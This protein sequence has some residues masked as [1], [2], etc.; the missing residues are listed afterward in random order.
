[1]QRFFP[2]PLV[3]GIVFSIALAILAD[4][5]LVLVQRALMPWQRAK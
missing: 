1:M 2:T 5:A 4:G 3:L